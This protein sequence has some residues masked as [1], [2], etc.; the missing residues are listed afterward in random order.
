MPP[1]IKGA[2][3]QSSVNCQLCGLRPCPLGR[4]TTKVCC[5]ASFQCASA[6]GSWPVWRLRRRQLCVGVMSAIRPRH[7]SV[8]VGVNAARL[9]KKKEMW[10]VKE[11][12]L[13]RG[14]RNA[15][16]KEIP[17]LNINEV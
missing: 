2:K 11:K 12:D 8:H 7:P 6:F 5:G 10:R 9:N 1:D 16:S 17:I 13:K 15:K 14:R 4:S 3:T